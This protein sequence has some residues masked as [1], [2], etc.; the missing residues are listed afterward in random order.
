M[1]TNSYTRHCNGNFGPEP[2]EAVKWSVSRLKRKLDGKVSIPK[3]KQKTFQTNR[4]FRTL[5]GL[6]PARN[7]GIQ[8]NPDSK[9]ANPDSKKANPDS[10]EVNP[11]SKKVNPDSKKVNP[12]SKKVNPDSKKV[13][14]DSTGP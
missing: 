2:R 9:K 1:K 4:A 11:D 6:P 5:S 3:D 10:T 14:P 8:V 7:P 12:G 13:N